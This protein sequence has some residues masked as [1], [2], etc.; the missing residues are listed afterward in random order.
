[1]AS[2][3]KTKFQTLC[4]QYEKYLTE[5]QGFPSLSNLR[6]PVPG[7]ATAT[8][9]TSAIDAALQQD[10]NVLAAKEKAANQLQGGQAPVTA[11]PAP[12]AAPVPGAT[13]NPTAQ[14]PKL[15]DAIE[16][17]PEVIRAKEKAA[18]A[19]A[20]QQKKPANTITNP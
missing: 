5:G 8:T 6:P 18:Q 20:L 2:E 3:T 14:D 13:T 17:H 12:N 10:P 4:E 9:G 15:V 11:A 7:G 19:L 16:N 1:M